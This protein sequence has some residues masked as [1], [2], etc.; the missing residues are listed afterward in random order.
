LTL[1]ICLLNFPDCPIAAA[2][3]MSGRCGPA[4]D[5]TDR[6]QG[7]RTKRLH[8]SPGQLPSG[9]LLD[10]FQQLKTEKEKLQQE[11]QEAAG[12]RV[13]GGEE[14]KK[15][16]VGTEELSEPILPIK[17][18]TGASSGR[19]GVK[20][21]TMCR[22]WLGVSTLLTCLAL[23]L[24]LA[25][26]TVW[27]LS[28]GLDPDQYLVLL[29]AGSVHTSV[30]TYRASRSNQGQL[31]ATETHFCELGQT[32][33]SSFVHS[34]AEAARF[35]SESDCV[36]ESVKLVPR[37]VLPH[38]SLV[39]GSTA[40]MR[41]LRLSQ[42]AIAQQ[43]LAN[44]SLALGGAVRGLEA[45]A[46]VLGGTE[47][48]RAGWLTAAMLSKGRV[49]ALDWGGASAQL[50]RPVADAAPDSRLN[51]VPLYS[52]SHMC[53]GQAEA[54]ARHKATLASTAML[55]MTSATKVIMVEDPCLPPGATTTAVPAASLFLS[56]CTTPANMTTM[57]Q[58]GNSTKTVQFIPSVLEAAARR[59]QCAALV[60][61]QFQPRSCRAQWA[62]Q[63]GE[64]T[65]LDPDT[66]PP[67]PPL[68]H[69]AFSTYWY[70]VKGLG[71][72]ESFQ[73]SVYR[74]A[75]ERVCERNMTDLAL[76]RLGGVAPA[77][78]FQ[79]QFMLELLTTGYHFDNSSWERIRF[80]RRVNGAEV[81]WTFGYAVMQADRGQHEQES[82]S[83]LVSLLCL[84]GVVTMLATAA[85]C[86]VCRPGSNYNRL[87]ENAV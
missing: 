78:C 65:C 66:I 85:W 39:L 9:A 44:L 20:A 50:T 31:N 46:I 1:N 68:P 29:D 51:E 54:R 14:E 12:A 13:E 3:K 75:V 7:G 2:V 56:P 72:P 10:Q 21:V 24:G 49:G 71:L 16:A 82:S 52:R 55:N 27:C 86:K 18:E 23:L 34:P 5:K 30:Y 79:A 28:L 48:G 26:L 43:I 25:G 22:G 32:G 81:G 74:A 6:R 57:L 60:Q 40:G 33:I 59:R 37:A 87:R 73:L 77:A 64:E 4:S 63:P 42:P 41:L 58:L 11:G 36:Q 45:N 83:S 38:S 47:E 84:A 61:E 67:P 17:A 76:T 80:V 62:V 53:Y 70:L 15:D 69:L 19:M 35:V 8:S